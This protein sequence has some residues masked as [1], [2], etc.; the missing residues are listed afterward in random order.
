MNFQWIKQ[1][2]LI[3]LQVIQNVTNIPRNYF[4]DILRLSRKFLQL[5]NESFR[6]NM[7]QENFTL[8]PILDTCEKFNHCLGVN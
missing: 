6:Q 5:R 1:S 8:N 3:F 2:K 4:G 7:N